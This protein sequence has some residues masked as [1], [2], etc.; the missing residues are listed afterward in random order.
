MNDEELTDDDLAAIEARCAAATPGPWK[1]WIEG[2]D[3]FAGDSIITTANDDMY[4]SPPLE[5][6]L[7]FIAAARQDVPRLLAEV[8]RL[9]RRL[10]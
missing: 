8:R 5:A 6:D 10:G 9:R 1:A 4:V 7:D 2:R 3:H